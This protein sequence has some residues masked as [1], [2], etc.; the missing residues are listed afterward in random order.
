MKWAFVFLLIKVYLQN[1]QTLDISF[2]KNI[3]KSTNHINLSWSLTILSG[4]FKA[5]G[6]KGQLIFVQI[7]RFN[8]YVNT[9]IKI[10]LF[11]VRNWH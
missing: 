7:W 6:S 3:K 10:N 5:E 4:L 11:P 1:D 9:V 8:E 2:L